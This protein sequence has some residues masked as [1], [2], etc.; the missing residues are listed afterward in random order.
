MRCG[1]VGGPSK[2]REAG[3]APGAPPWGPS[4]GEGFVGHGKGEDISYES[5]QLRVQTA[6]IGGK[7]WS[8]EAGPQAA[9]GI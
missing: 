1:V 5:R 2:A 4:R 9:A 8:D 6:G 3:W 7:N